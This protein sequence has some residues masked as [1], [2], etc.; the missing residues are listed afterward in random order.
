MLQ[1]DW[2]DYSKPHQMSVSCRCG[3]IALYF[4]FYG[5]LDAFRYA[6]CCDTLVRVTAT[7][8][9]KEESPEEWFVDFLEK[10]QEEDEVTLDD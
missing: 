3:Q 5:F 4:R 6:P 8:S 2:T 10:R 7:Y 1:N 9:T